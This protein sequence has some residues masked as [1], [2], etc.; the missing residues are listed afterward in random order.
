MLTIVEGAEAATKREFARYLDM[1]IKSTTEV[2]EEL[3]LSRDY[4]ILESRRWTELTAEGV[5]IRKM[6]CGLRARILEDAEAGD[7]AG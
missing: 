3:E 1:S 2:E 5:E 7:D 6:L 4:G